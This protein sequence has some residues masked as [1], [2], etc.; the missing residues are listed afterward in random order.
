MKVYYAHAICTYGSMQEKQGIR[1]IK[2]NFPNCKIVDPGSFANVVDK[3]NGGMEFC[4]KLVSSCDALVFSRLMNK[5][6]SGVGVEINHA[7]SEKLD[8]FELKKGELVPVKKS[9]KFISREETVDLY[10]E[11]RLWTRS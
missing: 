2:R 10:W 9:V 4:K 11:W 7:L 5:I 6:T 8:V 1:H 3:A